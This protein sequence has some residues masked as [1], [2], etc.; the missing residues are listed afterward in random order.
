MQSA[1]TRSPSSSNSDDGV[2][3]PKE[4]DAFVALVFTDVT[5]DAVR[6]EP[7][8]LPA[9]KGQ[10]VRLHPEEEVYFLLTDDTVDY[11]DDPDVGRAA[12]IEI[13]PDAKDVRAV[14]LGNIC[15]VA[16]F[17]DIDEARSWVRST[18]DEVN[19]RIR[20]AFPIDYRSLGVDSDSDISAG[21]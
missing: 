11:I 14:S 8:I 18:D 17:E 19:E 3:T 5:D 16:V 2:V 6:A 7:Q 13:S 20:S 9:I 10:P 1:A 21:T 12:T 15:L 4:A